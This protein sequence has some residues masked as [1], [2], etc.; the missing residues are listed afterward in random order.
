MM[1]FNLAL[2]CKEVSCILL[3]SI[4]WSG[5]KWA[6]L[7]RQRHQYPFLIAHLFENWLGVSVHVITFWMMCYLQTPK[8]RRRIAPLVELLSQVTIEEH[9]VP[10][11]VFW[12]F[13]TRVIPELISL[14]QGQ[15]PRNDQRPGVSRKALVHAE[16]VVWDDESRGD[17][18]QRHPKKK[19]PSCRTQRVGRGTL[20]FD[21]WEPIFTDNVCS[22]SEAYQS[23]AHGGE[24]VHNDFE[25]GNKVKCHIQGG[26][27]ADPARC[28]PEMYIKVVG[29]EELSISCQFGSLHVFCKM[30]A[31]QNG[32]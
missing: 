25:V 1:T 5:H 28:E 4:G 14:V 9:L 7:H 17:E 30:R 3:G 13:L 16:Y 19:V 12:A 24:G 11:V 26:L 23:V 22:E 10:T 20:D 27:L 8:V 21:R 2:Q 15:V 29:R 32:V 18:W 6:C 31:G